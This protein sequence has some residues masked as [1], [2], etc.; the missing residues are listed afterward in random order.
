MKRIAMILVVGFLNGIIGF[1][2]TMV[3]AKDA[4]ASDPSSASGQ[5]WSQFRGPTRDG[6]AADGP[7]L[8]ESWPT[9]G[10]GPKPAQNKNISGLPMSF[11]RSKRVSSR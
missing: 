5:A 3:L 11:P 7:K 1:M 9:N 8:Q 6:V 10:A 2:S 4:I